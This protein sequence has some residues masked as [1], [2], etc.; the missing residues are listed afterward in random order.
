MQ[1]ALLLID[2]QNDYFPGGTMELVGADGASKQAASLLAAFRASAWPVFHIQHIA[3]RPTATFFRPHTQGVE[4]HPNVL[5]TP[6][7]AVITKAYPNSFRETSLLASLRAAD[8]STM[9]VVGMMTHMCV[10]TTVRAAADLG[11]VCTVV[12]DACATKA[13]TFQAQTVQAAEVQAAYMAALQGSFGEVCS[14]AEVIARLP[15]QTAAG[16]QPQ[17]AS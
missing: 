17:A 7:E 16:L 10:D 4:I 1:T 12:H 13:L 8:V 6:G 14:T 2:I 15:S 5:P 9:V 3:T 11:F